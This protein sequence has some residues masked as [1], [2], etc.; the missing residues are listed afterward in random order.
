MNKS[1]SFLLRMDEPSPIH[2]DV[3][4]KYVSGKYRRRADCTV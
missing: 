1:P 3:R 2:S 4:C